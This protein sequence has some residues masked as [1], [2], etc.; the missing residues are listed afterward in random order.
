MFSCRP[1]IRELVF[2]G[3]AAA[4]WSCSTKSRPWMRSPS[5]PLTIWPA[6]PTGAKLP[7]PSEAAGYNPSFIKVIFVTSSITYFY[8]L[9]HCMTYKLQCYFYTMI[10]FRLQKYPAQAASGRVMDVT[11]GWCLI[12]YRKTL[13]FYFTETH[14][15]YLVAVNPSPSL[16]SW[17]WPCLSGVLSTWLPYG[18]NW[19]EA[20][21]HRSMVI[22]ITS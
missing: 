15:Y 21:G 12:C 20:G 16:Q 2:T 22:L 7:P 5:T 13:S 8:L 4:S 17:V 6:W 14:L 1:P 11:M 3:A 9:S 10:I 18:G 19:A